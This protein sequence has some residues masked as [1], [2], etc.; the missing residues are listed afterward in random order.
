MRRLTCA[1]LRFSTDLLSLHDCCLSPSHPRQCGVD[2]RERRLDGCDTV[3]DELVPLVERAQAEPGGTFEGRL[4]EQRRNGRGVRRD[5]ALHQLERARED[6]EE[7]R[8][9]LAAGPF[10]PP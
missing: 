4:D 7:A 1:F 6:V 10:C 9:R 2:A 5:L 8:L 3:R